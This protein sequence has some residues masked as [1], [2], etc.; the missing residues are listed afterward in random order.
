MNC[1]WLKAPTNGGVKG[2]EVR[3]NSTAT[4][5]CLP[6]YELKEGDKTR[7]CVANGSWSGSSP[8]CVCKYSYVRMYIRMYTIHTYVRTYVRTCTEE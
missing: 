1:S 4:Y 3:Y 6:G 7:M 2:N 8:I 5:E